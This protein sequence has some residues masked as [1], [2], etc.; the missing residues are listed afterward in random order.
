MGVKTP[1]RQEKLSGE[2][3][4]RENAFGYFFIGQVLMP[5]IV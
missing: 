5:K 4:E 1:D 3:E 2:G